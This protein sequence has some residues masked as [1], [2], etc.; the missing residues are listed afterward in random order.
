MKKTNPV[1]KQRKSLKNIRQWGQSLSTAQRKAVNDRILN[2]MKK[3]F[4]LKT[5]GKKITNLFK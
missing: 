2:K 1:S 4:S 5:F 3:D